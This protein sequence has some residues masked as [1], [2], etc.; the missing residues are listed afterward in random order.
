MANHADR[1]KKAKDAL[2]E[3]FSDTSVSQVRT[4]ESLE[5]LAGDIEVM[6]DSIP[7]EE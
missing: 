3:V 1:L 7:E 4:R 6:L 2:E 5:H